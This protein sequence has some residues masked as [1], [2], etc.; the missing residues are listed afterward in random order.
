M[1]QKLLEWLRAQRRGE[2][3]IAPPGT[4]GRVYGKRVEVEREGGGSMPTKAEPKATISARV[5]RADK[6][7][8]EDRGVISKPK[9]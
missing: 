8:W 1:F 7:E 4:R 9:E 2:V 5:F 6:E 3:R